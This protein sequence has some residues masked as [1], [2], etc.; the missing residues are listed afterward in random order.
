[1]PGSTS[2]RALGPFVALNCAAIPETLLESELFGHEKGAFT[3]AQSRKIGKFELA[4][5]GTILLDEISEM[6]LALQAKLL[7]VL[8]ERE[9]DRV[10]GKEPIS[11]DVRVLATTN[12]NL[13][14]Y[15]AEGKFRADLYYR[16][17]VIPLT[18]PALRERKSDIKLLVEHFMRQYLGEGVPL[19]TPPVLEA[20]M[21]HP[22][23]GNIRELQ[24]AVERAAILSQGRA[25]QETDFLLGNSLA[26]RVEKTVVADSGSSHGELIIRSG[27]TVHEMEKK[28]IFETLR[29]TGNNRTQAAELLGISIRT[30]RNKLN[31]YRGGLGDD[32][33]DEA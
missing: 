19:L 23:P 5:G 32:L 3:G 18:L 12:R 33:S 24:N 28:L 8:Q 16:L 31:E 6:E 7:R 9:I 13:A 2:P 15:V 4:H 20:L 1:M 22:W 21:A 25:P 30:L 10:G 27:M 29:S 14:D 17:N 11:I 26:A